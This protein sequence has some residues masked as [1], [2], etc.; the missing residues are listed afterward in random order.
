MNF[1]ISVAKRKQIPIM[2]EKMII[3]GEKKK[4]SIAILSPTILDRFWA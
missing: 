1:C 2:L 3:R 4:R